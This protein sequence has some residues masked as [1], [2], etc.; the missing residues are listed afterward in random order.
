[1]IGYKEKEG[2]HIVLEGNESMNLMVVLSEGVKAVRKWKLD[3]PLKTQCINDAQILDDKFSVI[4]VGNN[5]HPSSKKRPIIAR[6]TEPLKNR[7]HVF[8]GDFATDKSSKSSEG[9]NKP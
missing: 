5:Y 3:E 6:F 2:F 7:K 9:S 4:F 1:M 8:A